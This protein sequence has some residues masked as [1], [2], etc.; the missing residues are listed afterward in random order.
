MTGFCGSSHDEDEV[1]ANVA[2]GAV[3]HLVL[4]SQ[5]LTS[6]AARC[7]YQPLETDEWMW[8]EGDAPRP[9]GGHCKRC[10][11]TDSVAGGSP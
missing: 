8:T 10:D 11:P 5:L 3:S 2:D 9:T 4:P 7:G 1:W 6:Q